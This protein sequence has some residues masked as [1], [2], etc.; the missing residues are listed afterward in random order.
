MTLVSYKG[1]PQGLVL[2]SFL[3]NIIRS[4]VD[5]F[6]PSGCG[7]LQYADDLVVYMAHRLFSVANRLVQTACTSLNVFFSSMGLTI[8]ASKSEVNLFTRKHERPPIMVRVGSYASDV[9]FQIFGYFFRCWVAMELP[10]EVCA[11]KMS[12]KSELI[13]IGGRCFL[14]SASVLFDTAV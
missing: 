4:C 6:I 3:Y 10:R 9:M 12:P 14:G 13:E 8:S 7:F 1:L 5:R 2:N 11:T